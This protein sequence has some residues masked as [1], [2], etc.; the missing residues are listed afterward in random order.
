MLFPIIRARA[1]SQWELLFSLTTFFTLRQMQL[2]SLSL[3]TNLPIFHVLFL[4]R[5]LL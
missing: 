3:P 1:S 2:I 5:E 4:F